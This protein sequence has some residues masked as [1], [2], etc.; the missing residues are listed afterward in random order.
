M[1]GLM[2]HMWVELMVQVCV[3]GTHVRLARTRDKALALCCQA[4]AC[5]LLHRPAFKTGARGTQARGQEA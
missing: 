2:V 1:G 4:L 3:C 5:S